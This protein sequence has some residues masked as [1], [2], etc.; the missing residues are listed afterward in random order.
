MKNYF[1]N[2]RSTL[3][4]SVHRIDTRKLEFT[5]LGSGLTTH[6]GDW[7]FPRPCTQPHSV[8]DWSNA[9]LINVCQ[10]WNVPFLNHIF[11]LGFV[12]LRLK[13]LFSLSPLQT[14][15]WSTT[16]RTTHV[17]APSSW[18]SRRRMVSNLGTALQNLNVHLFV[19]QRPFSSSFSAQRSLS[20]T[21]LVFADPQLEMS[22][23]VFMDFLVEMIHWPAL[24][25]TY[26][27]I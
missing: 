7:Q 26:H 5:R 12:F 21:E 19:C 13:R 25:H 17:P 27:C 22:L 16:P 8:F 10:L 9:D 20:V 24:I 15:L 11:S 1:L 3:T 18:A 6:A 4:V 14:F 2:D 23:I